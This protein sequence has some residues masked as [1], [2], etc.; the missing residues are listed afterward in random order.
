M[1]GQS[2]KGG[3]EMAAMLRVVTLGRKLVAVPAVRV[4]PTLAERQ[5]QLMVMSAAGLAFVG[6]GALSL[7]DEGV[8]TSSWLLVQALSLIHI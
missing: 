4:V 7:F 8:L 6:S 5:R 2:R 3:A 1:Q